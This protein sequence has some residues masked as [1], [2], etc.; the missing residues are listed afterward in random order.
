VLGYSAAET[1]QFIGNNSALYRDTVFE[2]DLGEG[3]VVY[4][5]KCDGWE[6]VYTEAVL[7][8]EPGRLDRPEM[9]RQ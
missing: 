2:V 9:L 6:I 5:R 7:A 4:G 3:Q 1:E 8:K